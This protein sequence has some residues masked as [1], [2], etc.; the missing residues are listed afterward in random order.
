MPDD[1]FHNPYQFLPLGEAAKD[2][3]DWPLVDGLPSRATF[4]AEGCA[5]TR[6]SHAVYTKGD[7]ACHGRIICR[8]TLEDPVVVG[9]KHKR[10]P[11]GDDDYT[12]VEP[13]M[14]GDEPAIPASSLRGLITSLAEAASGS[15]LRVLTDGKP[16][17]WRVPAAGGSA[18]SALGR[19]HEKSDGLYLEP[20]TAPTI[21]RRN[22]SAGSSYAKWYRLFGGSLP[23]R[24]T[25]G[26]YKYRKDEDA[27]A[28]KT[29]PFAIDDF[30]K[31]FTLSG[32]LVDFPSREPIYYA[33][34]LAR[35]KFDQRGHPLENRT[36]VDERRINNTTEMILGQIC[37]NSE[38]KNISDMNILTS[39]KKDYIKGFVRILGGEDRDMAVTKKHE[40]FIPYDDLGVPRP[41][42]R[43]KPQ[44]IANFEA[45]AHQAADAIK[46]KVKAAKR[47]DQ[48]LRVARP[49]LPIGST[50]DMLRD[51]GSRQKN[52][53]WKPELRHGQIVFFDF[54]ETRDGCFVSALSF[55]SIWRDLVEKT[56][57]EDKT[58]AHI[59]SMWDFFDPEMRPFNSN[60]TTISP[61]EA[62]FGFVSTDQVKNGQRGAY[63]GRVRFSAA[64]LAN[65]VPD[66][67][68]NNL[69]W[70]GDEP[71]Q[72]EPKAPQYTRLKILG[73]PK[74]P[75]PALYFKPDDNGRPIVKHELATLNEPNGRK[76]YLHR[77]QIKRTDHRPPWETRHADENKNQKSAVRP[78]DP[79][80]CNNL[81]GFWFH[82]DFDNLTAAELDLLCFSLS[83]STSF[84]HKLG[85]GKPIGLGRVR[86]EP[87]AIL[88]IDRG[89]RYGSNVDLFS[90]PRYQHKWCLSGSA[91]P[92]WLYERE[93]A[94]SR[95]GNVAATDCCRKRADNHAAR[96]QGGLLQ[97]ILLTGDPNALVP[98]VR[99]T[100]PLAVG[101]ADD[102]DKTFTWFV[103]NTH[104]DVQPVAQALPSVKAGDER[105]NPIKRNSVPDR[106]GRQPR[107]PRR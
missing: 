5:T 40:I 86:I 103:N 100:Y 94:T 97:A 14:L 47:D 80:A 27:A 77:D 1:E 99:V 23:L 91:L 6:L 57:A 21:V 32:D 19:L 20:L 69:F 49:Y 59:A 65:P 70:Q 22:D 75:C 30:N 24:M 104:R 4:D 82:I 60:R 10:G 81:G 53:I 84:R 42:L 76:V 7:D 95:S 88:T 74:P 58:D 105:L 16:V 3:T 67:N 64:R 9:A 72:P 17:S 28:A 54:E 35:I 52:G 107:G 34:A 93:A 25:F 12:L 8:L 46:S 79:S 90:A 55:S 63:A 45:L 85:M 98:G 89:A 61:A 43:I 62:L 15:A 37:S 29:I 66:G 101:Q 73:Q 106:R 50:S 78:L 38:G 96:L 83:P 92:E 2:L 26:K 68:L 87:V 102:E 41:L 39:P 44:A 56:P 71:W 13:Y 11:S 48:R 18:L 31:T 36:R 51:R 33:R